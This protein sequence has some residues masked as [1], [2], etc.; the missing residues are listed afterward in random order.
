M[1]NRRLVLRMSLGGGI[2]GSLL[3]I[4]AGGILGSVF[5]W[6]LADL[7]LGLDGALLGG[8]VGCLSGAIYGAVLATGKDSDGG[9]K[10][11]AWPRAMVVQGLPPTASPET[12]HLGM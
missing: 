5:G 7:S 3:G 4:F 6:F 10:P 2:W 9:D 11:D 8:G 12:R 1:R